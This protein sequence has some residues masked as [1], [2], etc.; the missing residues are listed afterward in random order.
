MGSIFKF[1][2]GI[3]VVTILDVNDFPPSFAYPWHPTRPFIN[4]TV[5]ENKPEGTVL[6]KILAS[7]PDGSA[8][9]FDIEPP[10]EYFAIDKKLGE[11]TVLLQLVQCRALGSGCT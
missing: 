3:L 1:F 8:I 7:D 5:E 4:L 2:A 9:F 11:Y 10:N 6:T